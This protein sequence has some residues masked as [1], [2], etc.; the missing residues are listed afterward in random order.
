MSSLRYLEDVRKQPESLARVIAHQSGRG[1]DALASAA[2]RLRSA[3]SIVVTG[4]GSSLYAAIPLR[5]HLAQQGLR[6]ALID[7]SEL[8]HYESALLAGS[9]ALMVSRSG[10]SIEIEKLLERVHPSSVV[11]V[12]KSRTSRRARSRGTLRRWSW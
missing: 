4:M 1:A 2:E 12:T 3:S 5:L 7:A 8:L 9:V 11:A 6:V 10:E